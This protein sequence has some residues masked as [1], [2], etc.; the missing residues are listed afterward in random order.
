MAE[1]AKIEKFTPT[2]LANLRL[3]LSN[4]A[5]DSWQAA[6]VVAEFLNGRG[7]GASP[8]R[9]LPALLKMKGSVGDFD[10]MQQALETI[11]FVM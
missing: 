9:I 2:D 1:Q 6:G 10:R 5:F 3:E 11:A 4:I 7:Y 8:D